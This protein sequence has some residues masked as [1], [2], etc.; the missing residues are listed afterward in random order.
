VLLRFGIATRYADIEPFEG[1]LLGVFFISVGMAANL[2]LLGSGRDSSSPRWPCCF[3]AQG[4]D[5]VCAGE[6]GRPGQSRSDRFAFAGAS[7]EFGFVL[8]GVAVANTV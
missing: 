4:R 8:F 7:E 5:C 6:G 2:S 3:S 1:L